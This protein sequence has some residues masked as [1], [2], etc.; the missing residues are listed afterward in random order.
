MTKLLMK[1][2][3]KKTPFSRKTLETKR[4]IIGGGRGR[5][6]SAQDAW[7]GMLTMTRVK[8]ILFFKVLAFED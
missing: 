3:E 6:S 2:P 5:G 1:M 4:W 8:Q 7:V